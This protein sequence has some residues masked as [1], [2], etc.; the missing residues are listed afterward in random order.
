MP[1][2]VVPYK[3]Y[4]APNGKQFSLYSSYIPEGSVL[5]EKGYTINHPDG[6][7]GLGRAPFETEAEAQAWVDAHPNFPGMS[8]G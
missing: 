5:V 2:K 7:N 4:V 3:V 8:Q 1:G 6:T